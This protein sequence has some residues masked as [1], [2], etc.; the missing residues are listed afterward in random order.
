MSTSTPM[1]LLATAPVKPPHPQPQKA[2]APPH[3]AHFDALLRDASPPSIEQS[4]TTAFDQTGLFGKRGSLEAETSAP[5][6]QNVAVDEAPL[7]DAAPQDIAA[8][9]RS[10][11]PPPVSTASKAPE[12][13][14][15]NATAS[16]A[17]AKVS[18]E[19]PTIANSS[20]ASCGTPRIATRAQPPQPVLPRQRQQLF[21]SRQSAVFVAIHAIDQSLSVIARAGRMPATERARLRNAVRDLLAE[22][23]VSEAQVFLDGEMFIDSG[24]CVQWPR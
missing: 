20:G 11:A 23:G 17:A 8:L 5:D 24:G 2:A 19:K 18:V 9:E 3:V 21:T 6:S 10:A 12:A 14:H 16:P 22:H 1:H 15:E 4:Q 13:P 7:S